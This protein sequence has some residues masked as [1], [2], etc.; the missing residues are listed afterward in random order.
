M[1]TG[2]KAEQGGGEKLNSVSQLERMVVNLEQQVKQKEDTFLGVSEEK[3]EAIRQLCI[4]VDYHRSRYDHLREAISK[5]TV[6]I[7]RVA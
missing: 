2:S 5:K 4:L 7:K 6:H 1:E 3:R